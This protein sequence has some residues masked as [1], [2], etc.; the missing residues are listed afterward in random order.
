MNCAQE[1]VRE[2][3][4]FSLTAEISGIAIGLFMTVAEDY[5]FFLHYSFLLNAEKINPWR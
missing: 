4:M 3:A 2:V 5:L 1:T